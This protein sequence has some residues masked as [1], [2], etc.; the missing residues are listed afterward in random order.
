MTHDHQVL[1]SNPVTY[2]LVYITCR[3]RLLPDQFETM[4]TVDW[5]SNW[6]WPTCNTQYTDA[7]FLTSWFQKSQDEWSKMTNFFFSKK[8]RNMKSILPTKRCQRISVFLKLV[9]LCHLP[10]EI[11]NQKRSGKEGHICITL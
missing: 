2:V 7:S 5:S 11:L 6:W 9:I 1:V 10:Q 8:S 3:R 4:E